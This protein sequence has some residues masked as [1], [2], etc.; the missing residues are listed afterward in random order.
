MNSE[1]SGSPGTMVRRPDLPVPNASS[2][3]M[4][5]TPFF[6]R[7]PPW[8]ATQFW[9]RMGRMSRLNSTVL[10]GVLWKRE[11]IGQTASAA[12]ARIQRVAVFDLE[13]RKEDAWATA[14]ILSRNLIQRAATTRSTPHFRRRYG[15]RM[16]AAE[17]QMGRGEMKSV[18][19]SGAEDEGRPLGI[20]F[21][22]QVSSLTCISNSS[23]P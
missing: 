7:T 6:C 13:K 3:N 12:T 21:Q 18:L 17:A 19:S 8:Q 4:N 23:P 10:C 2:R 14:S 11:L 9:F 22:K 16:C 1:P 15:D 5:E 20:G